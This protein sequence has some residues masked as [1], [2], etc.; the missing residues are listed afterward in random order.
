MNSDSAFC[1]GRSHRI[2]QD[3]SVAGGNGSF[4]GGEKKSGKSSEPYVIV[5]DGCSSS[6]DT[7]VGARLLVRSAARVLRAPGKRSAASLREHYEGAARLALAQATLLDLNPQCVDATL[8]T[9]NVHAGEFIAACYGDGVIALQARCGGYLD[10]YSISFSD[11]YPLYPS[12]AEQP[13]RRRFF[14]SLSSNVKEVVHYRML[15]SDRSILL[16]ESHTS[17]DPLEI[18]AGKAEEYEYV[19]V[20]TDGIRSF[21]EVTRTETTK[22]VEPVALEKLIPDLLTFKSPA[23]AFAQRRLNKFLNECQ[24]KNRQHNDDLAVGVVHLGE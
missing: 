2:C 14:E 21:T 10:V 19:A 13:E 12:Y 5:A 15:S 3:Y 17:T 16:K 23:G 18:F 9:V 6:P 22:R 11:G 7:D 4:D 20:M 24:K 1:I 8:L